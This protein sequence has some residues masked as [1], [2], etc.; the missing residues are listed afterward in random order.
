VDTEKKHITLVSVWL[1]AMVNAGRVCLKEA[2]RNLWS[3]YLYAYTFTGNH[4]KLLL[5]WA[6]KEVRGAYIPSLGEPSFRYQTIILLIPCSAD[7]TATLFPS[8][9]GHRHA[10]FLQTSQQSFP[11]PLTD[12]SW[13]WPTGLSLNWYWWYRLRV[14]LD[15]GLLTDLFSSHR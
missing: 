10:R 2:C 1:T 4:R 3:S 13:V 14:Y 6:W 9:C 15:L 11:W 7:S 5:I 8:C 12:F